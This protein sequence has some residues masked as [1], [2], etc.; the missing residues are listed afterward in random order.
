MAVTIQIIS[1]GANISNTLDIY[2]NETGTFIFFVSVSKSTLSLGY[3]FEPPVGA[4]SF[5]VRDTGTCGAISEI[6]C[7]CDPQ[8]TW[9]PN[10]NGTFYREIIHTA[11]VPVSSLSLVKSDGYYTYS[12]NGTRVFNTGFNIDGSSTPA[13]TLST[14]DIWKN[15]AAN[16]INGPLNRTGIWSNQF[17]GSGLTKIML[18]LDTWI[19]FNF[20]LSGLTSGKT[21]YAGI[22]SDNDCKLI[23][24]GNTILD[25]Y[26]AA[27][28][29][30]SFMYWNIYPI[31]VGGGSSILGLFGL[32]RTWTSV[33]NLASF[34]CEVYD[35]TLSEITSATNINQ[36]NVIFTS[37]GKSIATV[38]QT[39]GGTYLASGYTC[40]DGGTYSDCTG[41]CIEKIV[42]TG[43]T[44]PISTTT[45]TASV[46]TLYYRLPNC[47]GVYCY[48]TQYTKNTYE[49]YLGTFQTGDKFYGAISG[50]KDYLYTWLND[51]VN[52]S[53]IP[54]CII[55]GL[56]RTT[57]AC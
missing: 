45:T 16:I 8:Y 21:Y 15:T 38:V 3:T 27:Q 1:A 20:C 31:V 18:P 7:S 36:L 41:N 30:N 4:N 5:Q 47:Y 40:L 55:T 42:C 17:I 35:N 56:S 34:G 19:G 51:S 25:T 10:G 50:N 13:L 48:M 52:L 14:N 23:L 44:T 37:S 2:T 53:I 54:S 32:N 26:L 28:S 24:D 57:D 39:T 46:P 12:A 22:G 33:P 49:G 11:T 29:L 9:I 43:S 6:S